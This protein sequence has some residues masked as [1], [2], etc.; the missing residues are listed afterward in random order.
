M[1]EFSPGDQV[2]PYFILELIGKGG[3]AEVYRAV[4]PRMKRDVALK[5][6]PDRFRSCRM[7]EFFARGVEVSGRLSHPGIAQAYDA[8]EAD[9]H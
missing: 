4:H 5:V 2:G 6:A 7:A 8:G 9:G 3:M 1:P